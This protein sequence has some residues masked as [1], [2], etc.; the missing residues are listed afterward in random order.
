MI[1]HMNIEGRWI[2][3]DQ[4]SDAEFFI[5]NCEG[6]I[7]VMA[8]CISD[9]EIIE[10]RDLR[11][12]H[13]ALRFETVVPSSGYRARHAMRFPSPDRCDHELTIFETWKRVQDDDPSRMKPVPAAMTASRV[14]VPQ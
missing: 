4:D 5:E 12:E 8:R 2:H 7:T 14:S 10:V 3:E 11:W 9:R 13:D 6:V 1:Q